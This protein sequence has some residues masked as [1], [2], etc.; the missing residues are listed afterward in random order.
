M[1]ED[2][3]GKEIKDPRFPRFSPFSITEQKEV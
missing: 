1:A 2:W 3:K